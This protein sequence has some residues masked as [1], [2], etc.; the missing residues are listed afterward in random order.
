MEVTNLME[1]M[2]EMNL[3]NSIQ[4]TGSCTCPIC[5]MDIK[6]YALNHLKPYYVTQSTSAS[7]VAYKLSTLQG[8]VDINA[9]IMEAIMIVS[10]NPRH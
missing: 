3:D 2:V 4:Q 5:R 10:K 7:M 6:A 8:R 1:Q 9:A